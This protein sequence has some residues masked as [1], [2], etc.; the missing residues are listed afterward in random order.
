[1]SKKNR[2]EELKKLLLNESVGS[3]GRI[4][5]LIQSGK[6][7]KIIDKITD[8]KTDTKVSSIVKKGYLTGNEQ[9]LDI[10]S[11]FISIEFMVILFLFLIEVFHQSHIEIIY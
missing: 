2:K 1:M 9:F 4:Y 6:L 5:Q 7:D 11:N 8:E 10:L 3:Y